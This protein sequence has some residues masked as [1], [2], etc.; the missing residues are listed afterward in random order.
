MPTNALAVYILKQLDITV[1]P[2]AREEP[3]TRERPITRDAPNDLAVYFLYFH[4]M[5]GPLQERDLQQE[6]ALLQDMPPT[7]LLFIF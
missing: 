4:A 5:G 3:A 7:T 6:S 1:S 2:T